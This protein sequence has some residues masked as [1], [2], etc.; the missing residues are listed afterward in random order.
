MIEVRRARPED[1]DA[2]GEIHA[3]AWEASHAAFFEPEFT[4]RAV[5]SRR[6]RWHGRIAEGTGT[7]LLAA[8]DGRP[9]AVSLQGPSPTRPGLVE[10]LSFYCHPDGW[11]GGI[12]AALMTGTLRRAHDDGS[13]RVHLWTL[14]DTPQARRFYTKC[15]FTETGAVRGFDYGDGRPVDQVEYERAC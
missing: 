5:A 3:A 6:T 4:A 15:G 13:P 14:R 2:L 10:I 11:G 1:G 12:A 9:M 7:I 8:V